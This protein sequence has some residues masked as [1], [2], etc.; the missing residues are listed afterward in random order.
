MREIK[1]RARDTI[2]GKMISWEELVAEPFSIGVLKSGKSDRYIPMQYTGLHDRNAREIYEG[3]IVQ[4]HNGSKL[5]VFWNDLS[6]GW[7]FAYIKDGERHHA[8]EVNITL[9]EVIGNIY[10]NQ[11][12]IRDNLVEGAQ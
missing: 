11:P 8:T 4:S 7:W 2:E 3:D 12:V 5:E 6:H 1:F 10:E 9:L